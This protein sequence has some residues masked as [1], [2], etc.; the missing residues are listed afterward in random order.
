MCKSSAVDPE[1]MQ[2]GQADRHTGMCVCCHWLAGLPWAPV[3]L[4]DCKQAACHV[5]NLVYI[6]MRFASILQ[7]FANLMVLCTGMLEDAN[8]KQASIQ[9]P[10]HGHGGIIPSTAWGN[11]PTRAWIPRQ[12]A[13]ICATLHRPSKVVH[14]P[15]LMHD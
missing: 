2:S 14:V 8:H 10:A 5:E 7:A 9:D 11:A 15:S 12:R 3:C 6:N 1:G 13:C 4:C